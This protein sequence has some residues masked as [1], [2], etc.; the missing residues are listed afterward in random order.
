MGS[1]VVLVFEKRPFD[2]SR[3]ATQVKV[4]YG[5]PLGVVGS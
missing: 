3:L 1:T 4:T 5:A 2:I